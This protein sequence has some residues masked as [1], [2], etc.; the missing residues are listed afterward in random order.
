MTTADALHL[1]Q[2]PSLSAPILTTLPLGTR[3]A[4]HSYSGEW[5]AVTTSDGTAGYVLRA[6][7]SVVP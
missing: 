5:V 2:E 6:Y 7:V 1:R 3:L 4:F